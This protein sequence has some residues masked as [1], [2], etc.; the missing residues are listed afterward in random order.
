M[1][2]LLVQN[3]RLLKLNSR[4]VVSDAS[5]YLLLPFLGASLLIS[6]LQYFGVFFG[7]K[8]IVPLI[9]VIFILLIG[10]GFRRMPKTA[11]PNKVWIMIFACF[12]ILFLI[13]CMPSIVA[14][15]PTS[16]ASINNDLVFYLSI[17]EWLSTKSYFAKPISDGF[18]PFFSIAE[19]HFSRNSRVGSDYLNTIGMNIF[20]IGAIHTFN[21]M[22]CFYV[23][24]LTLS[25]YYTT[26]YCFGL[27]QGIAS[28]AALLISINSFLFWMFTTQ[29]MP[30]IGGNAFFVL[31][32]GL[33]Y[34]SLVEKKYSYLLYTCL[35]VS[36]V[37][38]IYSEYTLYLILPIGL[39]ILLK[40]INDRENFKLYFKMLIAFICGLILLNPISLYLCIK[41][42]LFAFQTT[43]NA[44]GIVNYI[45]FWNQVLMVFGLKTLEYSYPG[46]WFS[47][48]AFAFL[49]VTVFGLLRIKGDLRIYLLIFSSFIIILLLYLAY[50]NKFSYGYYK[51]MMFSQPF[52][53]LLFSIGLYKLVEIKKTK[54][55]FFS[56]LIMIVL[57][58]TFR[59][60]QLEDIIIH[61]GELVTK[62]YEQLDDMKNTVPKKEIIAINGF[63]INDQHLIAYY[64]RDRKIIFNNPSSYFAPYHE[65]GLI[66]NYILSFNNDDVIDD[67][68]TLIWNNDR[69]K[70]NKNIGLSLGQGWHGLEQWNGIA[71]RWTT[72]KFSVKANN[73]NSGNYLIQFHAILPPNITQRTLEVYQ[74]DKLIDKIVIKSD[75]TNYNT[76][77]FHLEDNE[78][79]NFVVIEGA[80]KVGEDPRPLGIAV[81]NLSLIQK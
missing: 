37:I 79:L 68:S 69:F 76:K 27:K 81:Q 36:A 50:V 61:K 70:L 5:A 71:T 54:F 74:D 34:K 39:F 14:G 64:L 78:E 46:L 23:I 21:V 30:Q 49:V 33:I 43:Q 47:V 15:F 25:V 19:I 20:N 4:L 59:I 63:N 7:T 80:I 10:E 67:T 3:N 18:H 55:L 9:F 40:M 53:I 6:M 2:G 42:N 11:I 12:T 51:T 77:S 65:E 66:P 45:P 26:R 73:M 62:Q 38:S 24:L 58:N 60:Y 57:A 41:Y 22:S 75:T 56:F 35:S 31:S 17:P 72:E 1:F 52:V 32:I 16:F 28:L 8:Y 48:I 29:Y 13:Y 44:V